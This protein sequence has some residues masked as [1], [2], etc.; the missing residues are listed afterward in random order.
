MDLFGIFGY[1][2]SLFGNIVIEIF[3]NMTFMSK[4][5]ISLLH[6]MAI[7]WSS[8]HLSSC[9]KSYNFHLVNIRQNTIF[10]IIY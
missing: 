10:I 8:F 5:I 6:V 7:R 1:K 9:I 3:Y 2:V 4:M